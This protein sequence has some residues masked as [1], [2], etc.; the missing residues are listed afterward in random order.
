MKIEHKFISVRDLCAAYED[1]GEAGV[2]GY[3]GRLDIRPAYQREY[4][5]DDERRAKVIDTVRKGFPLNVMYWVKVPPKTLE[6]GTPSPVQFEVLDGQQRTLSI[7]RFVAGVFSI[8]APT[9]MLF[10]GLTEDQREKILNYELTVYI[11]EGEDSEKLD[12][13]KTINTAGVP[14]TNQELLNAIYTGLWLSSA[15][16]YFSKRTCSAVKLGAGYLTGSPERQEVLEKALSWASAGKI[17]KYMS[18]HQKDPNADE[19]WNY[20][21][22]V[23]EWVQQT[24]PEHREEMASVPWGPLYDKYGKHKLDPV[25]LEAEVEKLMADEDVTKKAGIYPYVLAVDDKE[26][27]KAERLLSVRPFSKNTKREAYTRQGEKCADARCGALFK[28]DE[29]EGDHIKPWHEGGRTVAANCQML[30]RACNQR[31]GGK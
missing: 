30:C 20:F 1:Q 19:L 16:R 29:M 26:R 15:K 18:E 11:C 2:V 28:F 21:K 23:I 7:C 25:A 4:V 13:F 24:F 27:L 14:L 31:K 12:W 5:Y 6:D 9:D 8:K 10:D 3:G 22:R 17:D